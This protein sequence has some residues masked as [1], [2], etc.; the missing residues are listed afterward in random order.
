MRDQRGG[1][2]RRRA[3]EGF[4]VLETV[5]VAAILSVILPIA[6]GV[7][8]GFQNTVLRAG[9]RSLTN[10]QVHLGVEQLDRQVRSAT[11]LYPPANESYGGLA[12]G[13]SLR[14]YTQANS[15]SLCDQWKVAN[16]SL[17]TR[18]W[19]PGATSASSWRVVADHIVN[20]GSNPPFVLDANQSFLGLLDVDVLAN[21]S[22][23]QGA[24]LEVRESVQARD[25]PLTIAPTCNTIPPG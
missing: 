1:R 21:E 8:L 19:P 23:S 12:A 9:A 16:G 4:T 15:T 7:V 13:F 3:E 10:D 18:T 2:P 20:A 14:I 5:V 6:F 17:Q 24:N 25:A 22:T 11:I